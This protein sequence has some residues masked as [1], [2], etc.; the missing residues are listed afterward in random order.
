MLLRENPFLLETALSELMYD[1][2]SDL[3]H[4]SWKKT[5]WKELEYDDAQILRM[6]PKVGERD[7]QCLN[8]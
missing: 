3:Y 1:T 8:A 4:R 7:V 6:F 2:T 5:L